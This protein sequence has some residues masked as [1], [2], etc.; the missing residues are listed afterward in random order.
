LFLEQSDIADPI[1]R[2][3]IN[4]IDYLVVSTAVLEFLINFVTAKYKKLFFK[5][6]L[7][8]ALFLAV[9]LCLF[10]YNKFFAGYAASG[11][12]GD[13]ATL[14]I[15]FR[16]IFLVLKVYGRIQKLSRYVQQFTDKPAQT[17]LF[18]FLSVILVGALLLMMNFSTKDGKGLDFIDALFTATSAVCVTGL[19]VVD[20]A[21]HYTIWGQT[22]IMILIQ[23]G[24]LGIMI[25]SFFTIFAVR[26]RVSLEDKLLLSY[27]LSEE[28]MNNLFR[29]LSTIVL[30]AF[31]I[32]A[33]GAI[34]LFMGFLPSMGGG[35]RTVFYAVFHSVSAFCNAGFALYTD[36]LES[37]RLQP[38]II[39]TIAALIIS[40]GIGF[41]VI[42]DIRTQT[43][44]FV[45]AL[46]KKN[47]RPVF[48]LSL[49]SR[50]VLR[51]TLILILSGLFFIYFLEHDHTMKNYRL[52][53]Q[54][55]A[56]FFQSVTL[57]TAGFNSISFQSLR[58]GTLLIMIVYM[59]IG[60]A[61]GSTAGGIK[62]NTLA[63]IGS[64]LSA[65]LHRR[66]QPIIENYSINPERIQRAYIVLLFGLVA[67]L[68]GTLILSLTEQA[69]FIQIFFE[70]TSAF[71][72]VGLSTG[73]TSGL[74]VPG[75]FVI[76]ILM[77]LGRLGPLTILSAASV[78]KARVNISY[79]QGEISIG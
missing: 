65:Y 25:L 55:L 30:T 34:L 43:I 36:S 19:I 12:A 76:I 5:E 59:F 28:D 4:V 56:A 64:S 18:S 20:T 78:S 54:Y 74:S 14:T 10:I 62:V 15:I 41:S 24:G 58:D 13:L 67:V 47:K 72:T 16:N 66:P 33:V 60:A 31:S 73:I 61:S 53:E 3:S 32:E 29:A 49:N 8:S 39:I 57:R 35:W 7:F 11:Y 38:L 21:T 27:M 52:G 51:Y 48:S 45:Q 26:K 9:F 22:I 42:A 69:S 75:K 63:V 6:N 23:I 1:I 77:Y 68:G 40:G 79:P 70:A 17:I 46:I 44:Q 71:G 50:V 2:L 37:F